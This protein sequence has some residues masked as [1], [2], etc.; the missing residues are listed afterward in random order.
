MVS[1]IFLFLIFFVSIFSA[2]AQSSEPSLFEQANLS[3]RAGKYEQALELYNKIPEKTAVLYYNMG[4]CAYKLKKTGYALLHWRR[5]ERD[6]GLCNRAELLDNIL[7]LKLARINGEVHTHHFVMNKM[8]I[9]AYSLIKAMPVL[10][11]QLIFLMLWLLL[12]LFIRPLYKKRY[13][14]ILAL[15]TMCSVASGLLLAFK[16]NFMNRQYA[17]IV[18]DI[19]LTSGPGENFTTLGQLAQATEVVV[20]K[21]SG[22][23]YKVKH[24][25]QS[26]WVS[27][28]GLEII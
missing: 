28:D 25:L 24:K 21:Q 22:T 12:F 6:W 20:Q 26:G 17:V 18:K 8:A 1:Y 19:A 5:A 2:H 14:V 15:L 7:F 16:Y 13:T 4:N 23:F 9:W 11:F 10:F 3:Y 27:K